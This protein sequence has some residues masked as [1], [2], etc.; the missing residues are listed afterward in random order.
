MQEPL[1]R[2]SRVEVGVSYSAE[3]PV[4]GSTQVDQQV[5][6]RP[7][8]NISVEFRISHFLFCIF[9]FCISYFLYPNPYFLSPISCSFFYLL[10]AAQADEGRCRPGREHFC[11]I[12]CASN[13]FGGKQEKPESRAL[14][15]FESYWQKDRSHLCTVC[16]CKC[17]YVS[18]S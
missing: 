7:G 3:R 18:C 12:S 10:G 17:M 1:E 15:C 9:V 6:C 2:T 16:I 11:G 4:M 14:P 8:A 5:G 13:Y